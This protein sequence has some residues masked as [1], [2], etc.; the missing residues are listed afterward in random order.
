MENGPEIEVG[1]RADNIAIK[2][3]ECKFVG[4]FFD[5]SQIPKD[6]RPQIAF[7]G[8]SNVGKSS[9]L[10]KL[11]GTKKMVKVS[12]TPGKTRSLNFFLINDRYYF[13]DLPGYGYAKVSKQMRDE[14]GRLIEDYL[15]N[16]KHLKG[17]ALLLD[18]RRDPTAEDI[19]LLSW[20]ADR[21]L[22]ALAVVTKTDKLTR[23]KA[24]R[25]VKQIQD[26]FNM[27]AIPFSTITG[28]GKKEL[29]AAIDALMSES[30]TL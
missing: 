23:D 24:N 17:L 27:T 18:S 13:V 16:S 22:A 19:Q 1:Q 2:N 26:R 28:V 30:K 4:S 21:K 25:K 8:R 12:K 6:A 5:L 3:L 7:A 15:E 11:L 10:N 14:W 29:L 20:I 9:L